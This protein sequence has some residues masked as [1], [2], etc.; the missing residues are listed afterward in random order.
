[1]QP[2][3]WTTVDKSKWGDGPWANEPDKMQWVDPVTNLPCLI[4][5]GPVGALCGYVGVPASHA[6]YGLSYEGSV[7][8]E[9]EEYLEISRKRM[10]VAVKLKDKGA[11]F[12][13]AFTKAYE[14]VERPEAT[15]AV[16]LAVRDLQVHG[17][18]TFAGG[19]RGHDDPSQ[20]ICHVPDTGESDTAWW[21][22]FDCAHAF[23]LSPKMEEYRRARADWPDTSKALTALDPEGKWK[24]VYRD[25]DYVR[26]QCAE[27]AKQLAAITLYLPDPIEEHSPSPASDANATSDQPSQDSAPENP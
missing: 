6:A 15:S 11:D 10:G 23:D 3:Q 26:G 17:G 13:E 9:F 24:D 22:G 7:S 5:R 25:V 18:L 16:G 20:G 14:G 1:M 19:C 8:K 27:L 2:M 4:V 12:G 21:F